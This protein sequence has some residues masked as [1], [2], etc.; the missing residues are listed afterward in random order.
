MDEQHAWW[1]YVFLKKSWIQVYGLTFSPRGGKKKKKWRSRHLNDEDASR[2]DEGESRD[3]DANNVKRR[4]DVIKQIRKV[5][6]EVSHHALKWR[7]CNGCDNTRCSL[8]AHAMQIHT[9]TRWGAGWWRGWEG[10]WDGAMTCDLCSHMTCGRRCYLQRGEGAGQ[11]AGWPHAPPLL[12]ES[13][14]QTLKL[15]LL[16]AHGRQERR[17]IL[18]LLHTHWERRQS[19]THT[20]LHTLW[21]RVYGT[22]SSAHISSNHHF[23]T[24]RK[25]C[26][27]QRNKWK[28]SQWMLHSNPTCTQL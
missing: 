23:S 17:G 18:T 10:V 24:P 4:D 12:L 15:H 3:Q 19:V 27:N 21:E 6:D 14:S 13:P 16:L 7:W 8:D 1:T 5:M 11:G 2:Q 20:L 28:H 9:H 22:D 25:T 26:L